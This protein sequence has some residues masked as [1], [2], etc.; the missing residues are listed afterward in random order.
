[1]RER[2]LSDPNLFLEDVGDRVIFD[3][4]QYVP[5]ILPY[6]KMLIDKNR[7][8]RGRF[9]MT[10]SCQ[11]TLMKDLTESL[12]GRVGVLSLLP[13]SILEKKK[14]PDIRAESTQEL[15][16]HSALCGSFP[17]VCVHS[18]I[19]PINWYSGY[20]M[21][22][23][24]RDLRNLYNV[25]S[26]RD[27]QRFL[28]LLAGRCSQVLNLSSIANELGVAVNTINRWVSVLEASYVIYLLP[29]YYRSLGKRIT[30]S[31]KVYFL[32]TGLVSYLVGLHDK[33][34]L[35]KGP[36]AGALFENH[37]ICETIKS[38]FNRGLRP[39]IYYLRTQNGLEIDLLIEKGSYL[40]PFEIKLTKTLN[41]GMARPIERFKK[42]FSK[43]RIKEAKIISLNDEEFYL[44]KNL[45][46]Q[47]MDSY[48]K[49]LKE[50]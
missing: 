20:L 8:I 18:E 24:E 4:I 10:G 13:F 37:F 45:L 26:L 9:I 11:F 48:L 40:Y 17:E 7:R 3:E 27:F 2:A 49:W 50:V 28:Q 29:P 33:E 36:M 22:Y 19:D 39:C 23:L 42:L 5:Q 12:A 44:S 1:M 6:I 38:F 14:I 16:V 47:S 46:A 31:P 15:F 30:K 43:L 32:D 21:T 34:H 25:G 35:M 41:I